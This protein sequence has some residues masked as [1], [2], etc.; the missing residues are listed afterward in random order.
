MS[1][2]HAAKKVASPK[3]TS[4]KTKTFPVGAALLAIAVIAVAALL[5][6]KPWQPAAP[7]VAEINP[8]TAYQKYLQ[9]TFLLDVRTQEEWNETHIPDTTLIPLD[10]LESRLSEL[11]RG[12]EIVVVCRSGNRSKQGA[13]ILAKAGFTAVSGMSGG[14]KEWS[15]AGYPVTSSAAE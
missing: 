3:K 2:K 5:Y 8:A 13:A 1:K 6:F 4:N 9:K 11:P 15:A 7:Q 12:Q 10:E 14:I